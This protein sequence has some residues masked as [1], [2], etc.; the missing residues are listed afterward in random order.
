MVEREVAA[1]GFTGLCGGRS[2]RVEGGCGEHL[3]G[4]HGE[5]EGHQGGAVVL[6]EVEALDF[7]VGVE[8]DFVA[9]GVELGNDLMGKKRVE[10]VSRTYLE[11][12]S[13]VVA[14]VNGVFERAG[15]GVELAAVDFDGLQGQRAVFEELVFAVLPLDYALWTLWVLRCGG[16]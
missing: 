1:L 15:I 9:L 12:F 10:G 16:C 3:R 4:R 8:E 13:S 14:R 2:E 11:H 7:V 5:V 6:E